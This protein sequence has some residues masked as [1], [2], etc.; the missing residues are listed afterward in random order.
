MGLIETIAESTT[1]PV[2]GILF[3][4]EMSNRVFSLFFFFFLSIQK[5]KQTL[6][7]REEKK[8]G[9]RYRTDKYSMSLPSIKHLTMNVTLEF[10]RAY[11]Y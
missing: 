10:I 4:F 1:P 8:R 6:I 5:P 2:A 3:F 9:N 11:F 7:H